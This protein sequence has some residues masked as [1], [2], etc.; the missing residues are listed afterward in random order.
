[1]DSLPLKDSN[2]VA[3]VEK[4][5]FSLEDERYISSSSLQILKGW[6]EHSL[7][8]DG[9]WLSLGDHYLFLKWLWEGIVPMVEVL[10]F[11]RQENPVR[12]RPSSSASTLSHSGEIVAPCREREGD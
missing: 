10:A 11:E 2:V 5:F 1:M 7:L 9:I 12:I 3:E 6:Q 4:D 8:I